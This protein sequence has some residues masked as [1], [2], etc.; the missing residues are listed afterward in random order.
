MNILVIN[1]ANR[2]FTNRSIIAEPIDVLNIATIIEKEYKNTRVIDMDLND[3]NN[4]ISNYLNEDNILV[5]VFD[6]QLP[7]HTSDAKINIFETIKKAKEKSNNIKSIIIGKTPSFY[8]EEFL[9]N[10]IDLII[11]GIADNKINEVI[12]YIN[13]INRLKEISNLIFKD[14]DNIIKTKEERI[15]NSFSNLPIPKRELLYLNDYM[16][17][18]TMITSRGCIG[19]CKFC[20]TPYFF[21]HWNGKNKDQVVDE[22][23]LLIKNY[24]TKKIMFLDDNFLVDKKRV[25]AICEEIEKRNIKCLYGCLCSIK[26]FDKEIIKRM[27]QVGFRWIHFGIE[28]GSSRLLKQMNKEMD[29]N[30]VKEIIKETKEIGYRIRNSFILDYP[31]TTKEDLIKTKELIL[32]LEPHEIRLHYLAYRVGTP[33]YEEN[34]NIINKT[35][36]IHSNKPNI[37]NKDLESEIDNLLK[38]LEKRNYNIITNDIDWN[39]YNNQ[40]KD[41]KIVAFTPIKYGMCWYE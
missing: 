21:G 13:D 6:Y 25:L 32:E 28:T 41:T 10:G 15:T 38:E 40:N 12:K 16:D 14:Q 27:Y 33:I 3:M 22:I 29:I 4:D 26:C 37:E 17:T 35:Q 24:R 2:P 1:P 30:R 11:K 31:T 5:F 18:R 36:Y 34:K 9:N 23:E 19:T 8:Y 7:L 39:I 20:S